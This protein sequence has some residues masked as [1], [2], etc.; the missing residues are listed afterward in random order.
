M[1]LNINLHSLEIA[2]QRMGAITQR[3]GLVIDVR[4]GMDSFSGIEI[5]LENGIEIE[6]WTDIKVQRESGILIYRGQHAVVYIQEHWS[7]YAVLRDGEKGRKVHLTDCGTLQSMKSQGRYERY[8]ATNNISGEF[9]VNGIG[10][11]GE[12]V[13]GTAK[14]KVCKNCLQQLNYKNY[15]WNRGEVFRT[16]GWDEF[17]KTYSSNFSK[18]PERKAGKFDAGYTEDWNQISKQYKI[19]QRFICELCGVKLRENPG[20]LQVHHVNGV[21]TDNDISNL[22]ALCL[23]CHHEQPGHNHVLVSNEKMQL[24]RELRQYQGLLNNI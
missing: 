19:T 16:F 21:K 12:K 8:V 3:E 7:I 6:N 17:F 13:D 23:H 14:L 18:I 20:L 24:I 1:N 15:V 22:R 10:E 2:V 9:Y 4:Q 5:E 11:Y